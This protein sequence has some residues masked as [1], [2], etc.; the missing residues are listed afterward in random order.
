ML[1]AVLPLLLPFAFLLSFLESPLFDRPA[2]TLA[3]LMALCASAAFAWTYSRTLEREMR[4]LMPGIRLER[5]RPDGSIPR[6]FESNKVKSPV[7]WIA[8][9]RGLNGFAWS[10]LFRRHIVITQGLLDRLDE[11]A[12]QFVLAHE[13]SHLKHGDIGASRL[14][15][16]MLHLELKLRL[17]VA[18]GIQALAGSDM[19]R[20]SLQVM[21]LWS[22][23]LFLILLPLD[24]WASRRIELRA[25]REGAMLTS[26]SD[27]I[28]ALEALSH[29]RIEPRHWMSGHPP[30][31]QRIASLSGKVL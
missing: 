9:T 22:R 13:L 29:G 17:L 8:R 6:W 12:L 20:L 2:D 27:G 11:R 23:L 26:A 5:W 1:G 30:L 19:A 21:R 25:D 31:D 18:H 15:S 24:R 3:A 16:S 14:W 7:L 10:G 28:R 4:E